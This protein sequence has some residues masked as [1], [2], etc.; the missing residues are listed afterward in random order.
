LVA[1]CVG[2]SVFHI[3]TSSFFDCVG[4]KRQSTLP[5]ERIR[6][7]GTRGGRITE[8]KKTRNVAPIYPRAARDERKQGVVILEATISPQ[9]CVSAAEVLRGVDPRLD[10]AAVFAVTQWEY[11]PTL[12]NGVPVPVLMTVTVNY[13]LN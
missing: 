12:L 11:T 1:H 8:P 5:L 9:G 13:R 2:L 6:A 3:L 7:R 4:G 10:A